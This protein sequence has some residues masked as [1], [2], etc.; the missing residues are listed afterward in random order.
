MITGVA[1]QIDEYVPKH[2]P[3][4]N[5]NEN[6]RIVSPPNMNNTSNINTTVKAVIMVRLNVLLI[7]S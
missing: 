3:I 7:A 4:N 1:T 2:T 5:A 6:P